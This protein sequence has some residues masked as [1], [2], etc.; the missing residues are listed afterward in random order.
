MAQFLAEKTG[1]Q[2]NLEVE[3]CMKLAVKN[4]Q[5]SMV[6]YLLSTYKESFKDTDCHFTAFQEL[7]GKDRSKMI[8]AMLGH[9]NGT[10][11]NFDKT[12][13]GKRCHEVDS[14]I[15]EASILVDK[16]LRFKQDRSGQ[17]IPQ[18]ELPS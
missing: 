16:H 9:S 2:F 15:D 4:S 5:I 8:Q 13:E 17:L 11:I 10:Q 18:L 7:Q 12:I 6:Q 14:Q 3:N 1:G